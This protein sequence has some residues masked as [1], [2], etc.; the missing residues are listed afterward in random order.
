MVTVETFNWRL[1]PYW[2]LQ[3]QAQVQLTSNSITLTVLDNR[4][5][6]LLKF[7]TEQE[8]GK[9]VHRCVCEEE[10]LHWLTPA[11][12]LDC[13]VNRDSIRLIMSVFN[14][15]TVRRSHL[16]LQHLPSGK[17][18]FDLLQLLHTYIPYKGKNDL[19]DHIDDKLEWVTAFSISY[20]RFTN[21]FSSDDTMRKTLSPDSWCKIWIYYT[22]L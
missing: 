11:L 8:V 21:T 1:N 4:W 17:L 6:H 5:R 7:L 2:K 22:C 16:V 9:P 20:K 15:P 18:T 19:T 13:L 10:T 3:V 14:I 12:L